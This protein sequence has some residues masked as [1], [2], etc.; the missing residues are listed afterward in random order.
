VPV[1]EGDLVTARGRDGVW[2]VVWVR[3]G[4]ARLAAVD[5]TGG[6]TGT[7][8]AVVDLALVEPEEGA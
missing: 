7:T 4:A 8:V 5:G 6:V 3:H 1:H 2:R